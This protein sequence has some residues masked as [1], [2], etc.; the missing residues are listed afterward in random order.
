MPQFVT[1]LSLTVI[2]L[3]DQ[4]KVITSKMCN[5]TENAFVFGNVTNLK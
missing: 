4:I 3:V 1:T 2:K 5:S